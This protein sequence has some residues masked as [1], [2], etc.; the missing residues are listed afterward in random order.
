MTVD[1]LSAFQELDFDSIAWMISGEQAFRDSMV[2]SRLSMIKEQPDHRDLKTVTKEEVEMIMAR[3]E[4]H[5]GLPDLSNREF[6]A[7]LSPHADSWLESIAQLARRIT[8]QRFGNMIGI[9]A[10]MY[11][12]NTCKSI[13]NYCGFSYGNKIRRLTLSLEQAV[14]EADILYDQGI[15][16][17]LLLTGESYA[18][19]P[20]SYFREIINR[21]K[22]RFSSIGI[23][24]YPLKKSEYAELRTCGL[25][26][27]AVYQETYDQVRYKEIHLRGMKKNFQYRLECPERAGQAKIRKV[28]IGALAGLSD[29]A[30]DVYFTG[31]HARS[32]IHK[33]WSSQISVSLP[34]L[35]PAEGLSGEQLPL[36]SDRYYVRY[37]CVLRLFLHDAGLYL[38]TRESARL[39]DS[40]SNICI[41]HMSAGSKTEPGGYSNHPSDEQFQV[42]DNRNVFET[43]ESIRKTGLEPV[44]VDWSAALK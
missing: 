28:A 13:C 34:R 20:I 2:P 44:F 29:P 17:L 8:R 43:A 5:S 11:L 35:Q 26:G 37:L 15:R 38:S 9:Y 33:Y 3:L 24:V 25:D 16:H 4:N 7:L 39:R 19:T 41:T 21:L 27:L 10:P 1:F 18:D 12:S 30:A 14:A 22:D 40:I 36:I 31:L 23:E 42:K 32:L 6:M